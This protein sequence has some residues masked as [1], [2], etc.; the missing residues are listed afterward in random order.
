L[1]ANPTSTSA[2]TLKH[3]EA[4]KKYVTP[5]MYPFFI[6]FVYA[7]LMPPFFDF[8]YTVIEHN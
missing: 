3:G 6:H 5:T 2:P 1:A 4:R 7:G 8:F